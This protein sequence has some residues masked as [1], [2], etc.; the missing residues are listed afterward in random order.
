MCFNPDQYGYF[1]I[2]GMKDFKGWAAID[3]NENLLYNIYNTTYGEPTPDYIIENKIRIVDT[4]NLIGFA[5]DLGQVIIKPQFE[6]A[7]SFHQGKAIIGQ[8]CKKIPWDAQA[9]E[10]D[11]HH[12][13]IICE[14][15]GYID[16][17]GKVLKIGSYSFDDI[18]KQIDWKMPG[19]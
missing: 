8:T 17:K 6:I 10:S 18:R 13:S 5:N 19:D 1:A 2:F 12:Y 3:A 7:T 14:R 16:T 9:K 11:C 15:H 4:N